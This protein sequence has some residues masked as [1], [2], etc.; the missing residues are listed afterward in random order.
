MEEENKKSKARK[1]TDAVCRDLPRLDKKYYKP[2]DFP[3]LQFWVLPSGTKTWYYQY[4]TKNKKYPQSKKLG[5]YPIV[6]VVE[7]TKKA[8]TEA[9][10]IFNGQDPRE[11]EKS[12]LLE[13]QL[14]E[15][16]RKYYAEELT[17]VNQYRPSTIKG[18]KAVF[19]PWI[20]RKTYEKDILNRL[21]RVEDIQYKKLSFLTP[22]M[23]KEL[24]Q[25]CGSRSPYVA[26]RLL[27]YLRKFWNDFVKIADNPFLLKKKYKY[28]EKVYEDYLSP[29]EL[30]RVMK[31]LVR[32]DERSGRLL[33]S[34]YKQWSL[35]P[36]SCLLLAFLLTT[37]RRP[38]EARSLTWGQY[39]RTGIKRI[40]LKKTKTSKKNNKT[41]FKL[42]DDAIK[43]LDL[44]STDRLNNPDSAF[45][46][47]TD[48]IRN[49]YIFPSKDYGRILK[50]GKCKTP[51]IINPNKTWA[52]VLKY[53]GIEREMKVY[54]TR[55]TF[56]TNYYSATK[57]IKA[58][59][60]ALGVT[61]K[62]ALKYAKL[63]EDTMVEGINK[64]IFFD[65]EKP[66][67]KQ[68]N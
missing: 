30:K 23:A 34:Y 50:N 63:L 32:R 58:T 45:Y 56:A 53:S 40:Q 11:T 47:T 21:E 4:R 44:I 5:N 24:F 13:L 49:K 17:T 29:V 12:E 27:E 37:G 19:G 43:I 20:F 9:L 18:I 38:E 16:I 64:I 60:E 25:V 3:G 55:H 2:G 65:D 8:K 10:K 39:I 1:L 36:V 54:A 61:E 22:K 62:I 48:D 31:N 14:G 28:S 67:L 66:L 52:N 68:V 7:A 15:V 57:D 26:N 35:S 41:T 33:Y 51:H 46:F 6:S 42:G 59:A